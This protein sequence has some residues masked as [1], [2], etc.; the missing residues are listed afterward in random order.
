MLPLFCV[1]GSGNNGSDV[2]SLFIENSEKI[3]NSQNAW[4]RLNMIFFCMKDLS[5]K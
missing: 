1:F 4:E 3:I 2:R 5:L